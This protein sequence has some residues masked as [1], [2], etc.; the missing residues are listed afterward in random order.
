MFARA[1]SAFLR[2]LA[3]FLIRAYQVILRPLFGGQ[4]RFHPSCSEYATEAFRQHPPLRAAR[5]TAGR[6][7][8]C[9]PFCQGG[10][11]PVPIPDVKAPFPEPQPAPE[12]R[13]TA[14]GRP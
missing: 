10:Y 7:L 12:G 3:L 11:D 13:T 9:Q 4:C 5:L 14:A 6:L 8:R 2:F 1:T